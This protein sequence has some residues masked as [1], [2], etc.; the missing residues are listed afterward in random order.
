MRPSRRHVLK[1]FA[2]TAA[3]TLARS[4]AADTATDTTWVPS[5]GWGGYGAPRKVLEIFMR[6]GVSF[7]GSFWWNT[8]EGGSTTAAS[9]GTGD[10]VLPNGV[11][12]TIT[13]GTPVVNT[14]PSAPYKLGKAADPLFKQSATSTRKL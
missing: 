10:V 5:G 4:G 12:Q 2:A 1:L 13:G 7:W 11:W 6:G 3:A 8:T 14:W 9:P